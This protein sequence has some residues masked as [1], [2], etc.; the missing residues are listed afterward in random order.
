MAAGDVLNTRALNRATLYRQRLLQRGGDVVDTIELLVGMQAQNPHDPYYGLWARLEDFDPGDLSRLLVE[1]GV[2][3]G[4]LMRATIH[5]VTARDYIS[6]RPDLQSVLQR[7]FASTSFAK[8]VRGI[9]PDR[10][11]N[12]AGELLTSAHLTRA[13]LAEALGKLFPW[14]PAASMAQASTYLLAVVQVPPRALWGE[15]GFPRWALAEQWLETELTHREAPDRL[16]LRYLGAF[17]PASVADMRT[18]SGLSGLRE[19]VNRLRPRLRSWRDQK[20]RELLDLPD[21][22]YPEPDTPAPPRFLPEYDNVLLAHSDR[23]RFM[24]DLAPEGWVGNLLV[25]GFYA[26]SWRIDRGGAL[27]VMVRVAPTKAQLNELETEARRLAVSTGANEIEI[28][29][30][31]VD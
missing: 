11:L 23:S 13:E 10:L 26:G 16:V 30:G 17:G 25:D 18:W 6:M 5:M 31:S 20:G 19:V 3:R 1:R 12:A 7:V 4:P 2:V 28:Q 14:V 15:S 21:A 9:E 8:D 22:I 27:R 24:N 29:V